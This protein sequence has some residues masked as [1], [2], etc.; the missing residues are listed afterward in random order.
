MSS[1]V[2]GAAQACPVNG[3]YLALAGYAPAECFGCFAAAVRVAPVGYA[4]LAAVAVHVEIADC[5]GLAFVVA[6]V[7]AH[8]AV[9]DCAGLAVVAAVVERELVAECVAAAARAGAG[10]AGLAA[11]AAAVVGYAAVAPDVAVARAALVALP[12]RAPQ[13]AFSRGLAFG[14]VARRGQQHQILLTMTEQPLR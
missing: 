8:V 1:A 14:P 3:R 13:V 4:A 9:V 10:Y 7:A 2:G 11:D 12:A 5:C 6:V